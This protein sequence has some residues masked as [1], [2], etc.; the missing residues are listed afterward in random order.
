MTLYTLQGR[1]VKRIC[2]LHCSYGVLQYLFLFVNG[3]DRH[4]LTILRAEAEAG[5]N[6]TLSA[7]DFYAYHTLSD[8]LL[9]DAL[10]NPRSGIQTHIYQ[11]WAYITPALRTSLSYWGL[12]PSFCQF[13]GRSSTH[14]TPLFH[15]RDFFPLFF[16]L[17]SRP[18][19]L[20]FSHIFSVVVVC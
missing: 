7:M 16:L 2:E 9:P 13:S 14:H 10:L 17:F 20:V 8:T 11:V 3:E 19:V 5:E 12:L 15:L 1:Q 4:H 6:K 18:L